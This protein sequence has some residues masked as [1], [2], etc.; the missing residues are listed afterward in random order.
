MQYYPSEVD[1]RFRI[2]Y[3]WRMGTLPLVEAGL[4]EDTQDWSSLPS[5]YGDP[6]ANLPD[7]SHLFDLKAW[8]RRLQEVVG[9][10]KSETDKSIWDIGDLLVQAEVIG[11]VK[12]KQLEKRAVKITGRAWKTLR[13]WKVTCRSIPPSL[14]RDTLNYSIHE[15]VA[16]FHDKGQQM[17][18]LDRAEELQAKWRALGK[19]TY[20]VREFE[21][22]INRLF[23]PI[24][25]NQSRDGVGAADEDTNPLV[26]V[27]I[28]VP[29]RQNTLDFLKKVAFARYEKHGHYRNLIVEMSAKYFQAHEGKLKA[30]LESEDHA[31]K[32]GPKENPNPLPD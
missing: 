14:R 3:H 12:D 18:A 24:D 1:A 22:E 27:K 9:S 20:P 15:V 4:L 10:G 17:M 8:D 2:A 7:W 25:N 28:D 16:K 19:K 32:R 31:L 13:N 21:K 6:Y 26:M 5:D 30:M 29:I 23:P 11:R